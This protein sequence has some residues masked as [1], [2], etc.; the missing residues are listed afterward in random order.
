[1]LVVC[2]NVQIQLQFADADNGITWMQEVQAELPW[3]PFVGRSYSKLAMLSGSK[4]S[5]S[6]LDIWHESIL[7]VFASVPK[8]STAS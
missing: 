1:M 6:N 4:G 3:K 5:L 2:L 7:T 8:H